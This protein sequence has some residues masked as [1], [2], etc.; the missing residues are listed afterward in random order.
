M[1]QYTPME[2]AEM[3][4]FESNFKI[5]KT[6]LALRKKKE[7]EKWKNRI[8]RLHEKCLSSGNVAKP[9]RQK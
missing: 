7:S 3:L 5:S 1:E 8:K 2:S 4:H 9:G 6:Q